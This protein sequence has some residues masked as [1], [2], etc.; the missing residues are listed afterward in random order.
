MRTTI[1]WTCTIAAGLVS[2]VIAVGLLGSPGASAGTTAE[3]LRFCGTFNGPAWTYDGVTDDE[4]RFIAS[5]NVPCFEQRPWIRLLAPRIQSTGTAD[6]VRFNDGAWSCLTARTLALGY[7]NSRAGAEARIVFVMPASPSTRAL[8][9]ALVARGAGAV[10]G[11][12]IGSGTA[13][14]PRGN[15]DEPQAL[16]VSSCTARPG[17]YWNRTLATGNLW[18]SYAGGGIT[19]L[20]AQGWVIDV[21]GRM[22]SSPNPVRFDGGDGWRCIIGANAAR[23]GKRVGACARTTNWRTSLEPRFAV[24]AG[25]VTSIERTLLLSTGYD[26]ALWLIA[27][28]SPPSFSEPRTCTTKGVSWRIGTSTGNSWL[29]GTSGGYPCPVAAAAAATLLERTRTATADQTNLK[30]VRDKWSCRFVAASRTT[31]CTWSGSNVPTSRRHMRIVFTP[32]RAGAATI[33]D[34]ALVR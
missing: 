34:A 21:S 31:S 33:V 28:Q 30:G 23:L 2:T 32:V 3:A 24:I 11:P 12:V 15:D 26:A 19:C 8:K 13:S 16:R 18:L 22:S 14:G 7:C 25:G 17:S 29:V 1:R 4:W 27:G 20:A 9:D 6:V 5:E 10:L